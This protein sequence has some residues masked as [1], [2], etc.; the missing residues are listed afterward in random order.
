MADLHL[1]RELHRFSSK[2]RE[3]LHEAGCFVCFHCL[4]GGLTSDIREWIDDDQT[5]LC[6]M[7][8]ID[9]LLTPVVLID[10]K[11]VALDKTLL[12]EMRAYWFSIPITFKEHEVSEKIRQGVKDLQERSHNL[13]AEKG[14][15]TDEAGVDMRTY[16]T[17]SWVPEKLMLM[18]TELAEAMEDYRAG[19]DLKA[20]TFRPDGKPEGFPTELADGVIR[21]L[22]LAEALGIDLADVIE[23]KHR[24]NTS[25]PWKHGGKI[26]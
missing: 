18:V 10:G 19:R 2:H 13:S 23:I 12:G 15:W 22:D 26:C 9:S 20:V 16:P 25:R 11:R 6:P 14:F 1:L 24:Y 4:G 8:G 17:K 3:E 21:I 5:A 7:C